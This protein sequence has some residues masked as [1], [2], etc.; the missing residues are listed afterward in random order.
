M[1]SVIEARESAGLDGAGASLASVVGMRGV[2]EGVEC[3]VGGIIWTRDNTSKHS[4]SVKS[5]REFISTG[6][7]V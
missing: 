5:P 2:A 7:E 3:D 6:S 4:A 1:S